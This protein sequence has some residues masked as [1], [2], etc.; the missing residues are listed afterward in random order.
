M[1]LKP[2]LKHLLSSCTGQ[3]LMNLQWNVFL[4][5]IKSMILSFNKT[6]GEAQRTNGLK[7]AA[8]VEGGVGERVGWPAAL[9]QSAKHRVR[10][11]WAGQAPWLCGA[12]L[13]L[14]WLAPLPQAPGHTDRASTLASLAGGGS[15]PNSGT[16][17]AARVPCPQRRGPRAASQPWL[18]VPANR[19]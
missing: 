10:C 13:S 16:Q 19:Q 11:S 17:A 7:R 3:D 18:P 5:F 9:V 12:Q 6:P 8:L 2:P 14:S 15:V 4:P 1:F